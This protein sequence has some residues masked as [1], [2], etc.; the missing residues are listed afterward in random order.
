VWHLV[1]VLLDVE[2]DQGPE[3]LERVQGVEIELLVLE[4]T[5]E[6][7]DHRVGEGDLDLGQ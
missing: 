6:R 3:A 1:V 2:C 7:L 4:R 5:P